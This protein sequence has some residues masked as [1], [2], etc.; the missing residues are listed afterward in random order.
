[1]RNSSNLFYYLSA[2]ALFIVL[3]FAFTIASVDDLLFLLKPTNSFVALLAD[4]PSVYLDNRGYFHQSLNIVIDKSCAGFN[5]WLLSFLVFVYLFLNHISRAWHK[6]FVLPTALFLG[7]LLTIFV[8]SSRIYAS[9]IIQNQTKF[10]QINQDYLHE[11][12]GIITNLSFLILAYYLTE[13][14]LIYKQFNAK[15]A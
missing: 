3:K 6:F 12:I 1:M 7:Y 15:S 13:K 11:A 2:A 8:N 14:F 10:I 9:I 5:F 4:S